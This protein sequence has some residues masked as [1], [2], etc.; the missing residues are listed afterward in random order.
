[1]TVREKVKLRH[2]DHDGVTSSHPDGAYYMRIGDRCQI[3][4]VGPML[5]T[6]REWSYVASEEF[7]DD[8]D[9]EEF[10]VLGTAE[11]SFRKLVLARGFVSMIFKVMKE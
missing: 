4:V 9:I 8:V 3:I 11:E 5:L 6:P 1:M 10:A 7:G 2:H